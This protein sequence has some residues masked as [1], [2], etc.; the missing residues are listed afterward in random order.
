MSTAYRSWAC[1]TGIRRKYDRSEVAL[2]AIVTLAGQDY[3]ARLL[4]IA[5][6]GAMIE[7]AASFPPAASFLLRCGSISAGAVIV[8]EKGGRYGVSFRSPLSDRQVTEQLSRNGAIGSRQRANSPIPGCVD[9][10]PAATR[11]EP[12]PVSGPTSLGAAHEQVELCMI[13]LEAIMEGE[14]SDIAQFSAV[15]LRLRQANVV[16]TQIALE[17]C[18]HPAT[19]KGAPSGLRDLE[20]TELAV[21][22]MISEHVQQWTMQTVQENWRGYCRATGKVLAAVRTLMATE[23]ALLCR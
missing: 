7:C 22:Q 1:S 19:V 11:S 6:G 21:S 8:W 5:H 14:L 2:P 10:S 13:S 17:A 4:N 9:T 18:R 3:S 16:R 15:R 20:R 12:G 23:K